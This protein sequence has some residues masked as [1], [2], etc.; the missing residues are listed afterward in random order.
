MLNMHIWCKQKWFPQK[1]W[2]TLIKHTLHTYME[3][4]QLIDCFIFCLFTLTLVFIVFRCLASLLL[5]KLPWWNNPKKGERESETDKL[6]GQEI[7]WH[8]CNTFQLVYIER[9]LYFSLLEYNKL[10]GIRRTSLSLSLTHSAWHTLYGSNEMFICD[11]ILTVHAFSIIFETT[12]RIYG[13]LYYRC[14]SK[15]QSDSWQNCRFI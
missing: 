11:F 8:K 6:L 2:S 3:E 13:H 15:L 4:I 5:H 1:L 7:S 9:I 12:C 14:S 10:N